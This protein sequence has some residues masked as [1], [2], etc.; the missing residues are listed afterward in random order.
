MVHNNYFNAE[1]NAQVKA[2]Y[3][4]IT[5]L[6][7]TYGIIMYSLEKNLHQVLVVLPE[8]DKHTTK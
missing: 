2:S 3:V 6:F 4:L 5:I 1:R 8:I 7:D